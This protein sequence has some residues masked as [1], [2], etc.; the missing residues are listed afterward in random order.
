DFQLIIEHLEP[1]GAG[2]A[3]REFEALKRRLQAEG[4]FDTEHKKA[5]PTFPRRLGVITS[6]SGAAVRDVLKVLRRRA[7][8]I[9]VTIFPAQ[10]QGKGAAEE[11]IEALDIALQR[12]D[13]DV[14]LLTRGGGSI[15]DLSAFNDERLA[16][17]VAA[18]GIP[19][20]SAVGHEIDFTITDFVADRRA[21]TPS[22]AAELISPDTPVLLQT[23]A[24]LSQRVRSNMQRR[25]ALEKQHL[26]R[27][28]GRLQRGAPASLLRQQQQRVDG[29]DLR[30]LRV[31][32]NTLA[33]RQREL[34]VQSRHLQA[35]NPERRLLLLKQR[36]AG[37][38]DDLQ[39]AW[40]QHQRRRE[41]HL[42]AA[43]RQLNAVSPLATMRRGYAVLRG[44]ED[45]KVITR[46]AQ[47]DRGDRIQALLA[48][49]R[50]ELRVDKVEPGLTHTPAKDLDD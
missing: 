17:A 39:Q 44:A 42:A 21:P 34:G 8:Q 30:L 29:L 11:L 38:P 2:S 43:G 50:A 23:V 26:A 14:L 41:E 20:V 35:Q 28:G 45:G 9:A 5:L 33:A 24:K 1:A 36:F 22:A 15:E 19:V 25:L 47:L 31:M 46:A 10:V 37:L 4:L 6:P 49:G 18:A 48:D 27:L 3:Q 40:Q 13:C 16:R 7:P 12:G 32:R